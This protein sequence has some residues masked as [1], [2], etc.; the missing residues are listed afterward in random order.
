MENEPVKRK[1]TYQVGWRSGSIEIDEKG[2]AVAKPR[3]TTD[4]RLDHLW[5]LVRPLVVSV[6]LPSGKLLEGALLML[7]F[8]GFA[9]TLL[10]IVY[11]LA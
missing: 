11:L 8:A 10:A 2:K 7:P 6:A 3:L 1:I 4:S 9:A 5:K